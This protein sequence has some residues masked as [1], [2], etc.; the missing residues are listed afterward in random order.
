MKKSFEITKREIPLILDFHVSWNSTYSMLDRLRQFKQIIN[1]IS[2]DPD[3]IDGLTSIQ[4]LK[5]KTLMLNYTDWILIE[6]L[7]YVLSRFDQVTK[8]LSN[9][10]YPSLSIAFIAQ[11]MLENFLLSVL[12]NE[13]SDIKELKQ[14]FLPI[15]KHNFIEKIS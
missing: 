9:R 4:R 3:K 12:A 7:I 11:K 15:F 13:S 10:K 1:E 8:I 6:A 5:L 14:A 2:N